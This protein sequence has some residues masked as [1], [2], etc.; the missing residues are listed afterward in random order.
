MDVN[1][2]IHWVNQYGYWALFFCL[3]LGIVGMPI[4]DEAVVMTGGFVT[5]LNLLHVFPAFLVT[6]LG[7]ISGLTLGFVWGRVL[8]APIL[9]RLAK[10]KNLARYIDKSQELI[11]RYGSF[12]LCI[13]YFIPIV[14]HVVPYVAGV[15]KM[16]YWRYALFSY[17]TGLVW[18]LLFFTAGRYSGVHLEQIG[19]TIDSYG[20]YIVVITV[21]V[22]ARILTLFWLRKN[23]ERSRRSKS[24][25]IELDGT[26][27]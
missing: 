23:R 7:V 8:G 16:A 21:F 13:S 17:S 9:D 15:A 3:W 22:G 27:R 4:P 20:F 25:I 26:K 18:T 1:D 5:S 14:R 2:V 24:A 6:Y 12:T 10:K 11:N 19:R